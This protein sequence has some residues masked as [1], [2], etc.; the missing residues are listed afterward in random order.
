[1]DRCCW[2]RIR[3]SIFFSANSSAT[4][5]VF[6]VTQVAQD[7]VRIEGLDGLDVEVEVFD[8]MLHDSDDLFVD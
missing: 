4:C 6:Q 2:C 1:M 5:G 7:M 3:A 8:Q